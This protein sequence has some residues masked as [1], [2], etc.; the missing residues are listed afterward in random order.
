MRC[1][2]RVTLLAGLCLLAACVTRSGGAW[3]REAEAGPARVSALVIG[4]ADGSSTTR[5]LARALES[6]DREGLRLAFW[7]GRDIPR[8]RA[9]KRAETD[10]PEIQTVLDTLG[11]VPVYAVGDPARWRCGLRAPAGTLSPDHHYVVDLGA[12]GHSEVVSVCEGVGEALGCQVSEPS[13]SVLA[14]FV[15]VDETPWAFPD[16][17]RGPETEAVNA[18]LEALLEAL[19]PA[20]DTPHILVTHL[21]IESSGTHGQGGWRVTSTFIH[22]APVIR[23][24]LTGGRFDGVIAGH[25]RN[26]Q[27]VED[28]GDAVVRSSRVF[29]RRPVFQVVA[30][31]AG[32]PDAQHPFGPRLHPRWQGIALRPDHS[33]PRAGFARLDFGAEEVRAHLV[34]LGGGAPLHTSQD[35]GLLRPAHPTERS[36][37]SLAPCRDCD[38]GTGAADHLQPLEP[39][40]DGEAEGARGRR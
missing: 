12:D 14:R 37:P 18:R 25:E 31:S 20:L 19:P 29:L 32:D 34:S 28:L 1:S 9:C 13:P 16:L 38:P 2:T 3:S 4:G 15:V 30:G 24:A 40:R 36:L 27:L 7:L 5:R 33:S 17:D 6:T 39:R 10:G 22:H 23:A 21:P 35:F 11:D 8:E 26:L